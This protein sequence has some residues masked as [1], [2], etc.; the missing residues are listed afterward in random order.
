MLLQLAGAAVLVGLLG[1][2]HCAGMCGGLA[3]ALSR[4]GSGSWPAWKLQ[5]GYSA[6]R[7]ASY[8][9]AG[10]LAG[11]LAGTA[12][13]AK[14]I[15]PVQFGLYLLANVML[16]GLG[17]HLAGWSSFIGRLEV[18]GRWLWKRISPA[19]GR[20]LPVNSWPRAVGA[21]VLW[22]W[23]PCG[24]VYSMLATAMLAGHAAGGA[25]VMLAFGLGT[26]PNVVGAGLVLRWLSPA[27]WRPVARL[28]AGGLVAGFG[29]FGLFHAAAL[30]SLLRQGLACL[31]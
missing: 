13:L 30:A 14:D 6:G 29:V 4:A 2:V 16:I 12:L 10:A 3:T 1:G 28:V 17:L 8:S 5:L 15:L 19:L 11:S 24:L 31:V 21:G 18:P 20:F 27:G 26:L 23:V 25:L 9:V 22:G 7:L